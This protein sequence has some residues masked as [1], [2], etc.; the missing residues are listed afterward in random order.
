MRLPSPTDGWWGRETAR[1][2]SCVLSAVGWAGL[3]S[4]DVEARRV[5]D[6]TGA[7]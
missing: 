6:E 1:E 3:G 7:A 2:I 4:N 5:G